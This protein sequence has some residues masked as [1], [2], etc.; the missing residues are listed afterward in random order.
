ASQGAGH[1]ASVS[2]L[3]SIE[4]IDMTGSGDNRVVLGVKDVQ[5]MAGMNL[6]NSGTQA[7]QGWTNGSYVFPTRVRRHQL[8][9]DG[10]A[11]DVLELRHADSGWVNAGTVFHG[12]TPYTVYDSGIAGSQ[13]E[14][15]EVIVA[16]AVTT[17]VDA[18][19]SR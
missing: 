5:D 19:G 15:V 16:G 9:V 14:R 17:V 4:H 18:L 13:F 7:A 2:R 11:G 10:N 3:E 8:V 12:G 1:P 6:I